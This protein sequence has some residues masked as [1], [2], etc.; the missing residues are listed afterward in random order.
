[1][2]YHS[3]LSGDIAAVARNVIARDGVSRLALVGF[4][5][6]GNLVLKLAVS[7]ER[8]RRRSFARSQHVVRRSIWR[9][10]PILCTSLGTGFT[11]LILVGAAAEDAPQGAP[12][13]GAL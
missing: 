5:M 12:V 7:G 10:L 11:K 8:K 1:V 3:G 6:G 13:S 4:S 9:C 2:L